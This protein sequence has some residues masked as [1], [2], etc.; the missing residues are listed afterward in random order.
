VCS[1]QKQIH[2]QKAG[3]SKNGMPHSCQSFIPPM[4][5][6]DYPLDITGFFF[7]NNPPKFSAMGFVPIGPAKSK[8]LLH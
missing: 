6:G 3:T 1:R 2:P 7:E 5:P 8:P 4:V